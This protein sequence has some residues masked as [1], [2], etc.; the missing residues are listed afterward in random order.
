MVSAQMHAAVVNLHRNKSGAYGNAWK[1][2]GEVMSV[3][4][5]LA[6]KVDRLTA[7]GTT[8]DE[9]ALD[10]AVDLLVYA[11]K[12]QTFL[13]DLDPAVAAALFDPALPSPY[14]DGTAG[15]EALWVALPVEPL[16]VGY[17]TPIDEAVARVEAAFADLEHQFDAATPQAAVA[18]RSASAAVLTRAAA[19]LVDAACRADPDGLAAFVDRWTSRDRHA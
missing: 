11:I 9:N 12:Y 14:S 5:N 1:K 7:G 16:K 3:L 10:T 6:R 2:R 8:R 15:F 4:A 19:V 17:D 13:A 18:D